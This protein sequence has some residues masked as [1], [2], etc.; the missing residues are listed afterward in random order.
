MV[1]K[2]VRNR[3]KSS[4]VIYGRC[5]NV[6]GKNLLYT[7]DISSTSYLPR[8]VNVVKERP[9]ILFSPYSFSFANSLC[10]IYTRRVARQY[11]I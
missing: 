4:D 6:F 2:G 8:L 7:L 9:L 10:A 11:G 5:F 3:Q 1:D